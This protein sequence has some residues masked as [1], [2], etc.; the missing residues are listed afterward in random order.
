M[1]CILVFGSFVACGPSAEDCTV[2]VPSSA[3][4]VRDGEEFTDATGAHVY[5]CPGATA[6]IDAAHQTLYV[7][8]GANADFSGADSTVYADA[9]ATLELGGAGT[10]AYVEADV[11]VDSK[12]IE[13]EVLTCKDV[14]LS[15]EP[16]C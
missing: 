11:V 6:Q 7:G 5:L 10:T 12:A 4:I 8:A 13:Q 2:A 1:R 16:E 3:A 15:G 14:I 9:G